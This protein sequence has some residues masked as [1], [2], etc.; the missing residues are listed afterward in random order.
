MAKEHNGIVRYNNFNGKSENCGMDLN[1]GKFTA[2]VNGAYLLMFNGMKANGKKF[3]DMMMKVE[4]KTV[5]WMGTRVENH[6]STGPVPMTVLVNMQAGQKAWVEMQ[7]HTVYGLPA[8]DSLFSLNNKATH[9][10]GLLIH[11]NDW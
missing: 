2:P 4:G 9:F 3:L 10:V 7:D 1:S 11:K 6:Y 5:A 8:G